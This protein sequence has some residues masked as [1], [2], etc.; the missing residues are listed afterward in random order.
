MSQDIKKH[1]TTEEADL[2]LEKY[3]DG[4]TTNA[5][6]EYLQDFLRQEDLPARFEAERALFGFFAQEK[7]SMDSSEKAPF[8]IEMPLLSNELKG[9]EKILPSNLWL[10]LNPVL[11]WSF[12]AAVLVAGVFI[13]DNRIQTQ[14]SNVAYIDGIRCTNTKEVT[15]LA[16][17]SIDQIDLESDEVAGTVNK[18]N[19]KDLVESQLQQFSEQK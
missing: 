6:Q 19:D 17:A 18:M 1:L 12:A 11:R 10:R 2:L 14:N 16:I 8:E 5:E 3:Y 4:A 15:A 7:L 13:L 9:K